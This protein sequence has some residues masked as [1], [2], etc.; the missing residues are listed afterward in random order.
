MFDF[1]I[2]G[3]IQ[4]PEINRPRNGVTLC[5]TMHGYFDEFMVYFE[6]TGIEPHTYTIDTYFGEDLIEGLPVT[7]Q[8]RLT[9]ERTIDPPSSRLLALHCAI[10]RILHMSGAG[11]CIDKVLRDIGDNDVKADGSTALGPIVSGI[12]SGRNV[13]ISA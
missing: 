1:G 6:P 10:S 11:V 5:T 13:S 4:G 9:P 3:L 7:S 2:L 8:L 12:L